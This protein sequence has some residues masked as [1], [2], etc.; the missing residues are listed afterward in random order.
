[1]I[2]EVFGA[3]RAELRRQ[4]RQRRNS[5]RVT[6]ST[7]AERLAEFKDDKREQEWLAQQHFELEGE[8]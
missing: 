2:D 3:A 8:K 6:P 5:W 4:R 1:M 7:L